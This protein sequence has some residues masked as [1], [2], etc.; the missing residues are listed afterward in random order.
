[1]TDTTLAADIDRVF[2]AQA[3]GSARPTTAE[4]R[5]EKLR[6]LRA[7][8]EAHFP[9]VLQAL[10]ADLGKPPF[11]GAMD[12]GAAFPEI[13]EAIASLDAW[14]APTEVSLSPYAAPGAA[15]EVQYQP[16]GRVLIFGPWN[17][18]FGL[19]FQPLAGAIAAGNTAVLKPSELVPQTSAICA[20]IVRETFAESEVALFEGGPEVAEALL[21]KPFEHIFFTGST[22]VG[23]KVMAAA[24]RH[25]SSVT[26]ELGGKCP[27]IIDDGYDI[28]RAAGRIGWGKFLNAGQVCLSPDHAWVPKAKRD[29]FVA[30]MRAYID[31]AYRPDGAFNGADMA[32]ILNDRHVS[33]LTTLIDDAV[34]RG[35]TIVTGGAVENGKLLPTIL[36]DVVPDSAIMGEEIFGPI[37]P[38]LTYDATEAMLDKLTAGDKPLAL[39]VFSDR[40]DFVED[41]I[42]R[43]SSGGVTVNDVLQHATEPNLPMGGVGASGLGA[44]HGIHTFRALSHPR[45]VYR[46]A[47]ENPIEGFL[48]PPYG[49]RMPS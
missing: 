25:L 16:L 11:E 26:L 38:V 14:M 45:S 6:R 24:G 17:F 31:R 39:Y 27:A 28:D 5:R 42:A 35:A 10:A 29:A 9:A 49:D 44:Y 33:R 20:K 2:K 21:E 36:V 18:P 47:P 22:A 32:R 7:A 4:E 43:T 23:R 3:R 34:A 46:Q 1:M 40:P 15:A 8:I 48:R 37:L 41:V 12:A 13:D 30:A 19:L